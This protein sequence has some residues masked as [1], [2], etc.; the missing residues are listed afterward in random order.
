[1]AFVASP[2][3]D[4]VE[5]LLT[6]L[7]SGVARE[8]NTFSL[9][10]EYYFENSP[11]NPESVRVA[12]IRGK[13]IYHFVEGQDFIADSEKITWK[14]KDGNLPDIGSKFYINYYRADTEPVLSDRNAGSVT[15]TFAEAFGRELAVLYQQ[16]LL[17][18]ESGFVNTAKGDSLD[19]V[20][21]ILGE[22][23]SRKSGDYATGEVLFYR[24]SPATADIFIN[25]GLQVATDTE[26]LKIYETTQE[27]TL[28]KG[29][30][31]VLVPVRAAKKGQEGI[32]EA[33]TI[34]IMVQPVL[35][36]DG[37]INPNS[38]S[39]T[40]VEEKDDE[41]RERAK[42]ALEAAGKTT[43]NALK[44]ALL[45][46]PELWGKDIKVEEDFSQGN[47]LVRVY[48]DTEGTEDVV[49]KIDQKIFETK[50]SGIRVVHNLSSEE[51]KLKIDL[52]KIPLSLKVT[53]SLAD[54]SISS[55][56]KEILKEQ[57]SFVIKSYFEK[58]KIGESAL[59]NKLIAIVLGIEGV[60]NV[61]VDIE[62]G[63]KAGSNE[64]MVLEKLR[65]TIAD[66]PVF[67]D[68]RIQAV[69]TDKKL[70]S[71][72]VEKSIKD[73]ANSFMESTGNKIL[74][75]AFME[76][77]KGNGYNIGSLAFDTESSETGLIKR[78]IMQGEEKINENEVFVLRNI[79]IKVS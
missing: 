44:Y 27:K 52:K 28:R 34:K 21:A 56:K 45:S 3:L 70:D 10:T 20:V 8:E 22:N 62:D 51:G 37:I 67:V 46:I 76:A 40:G 59:K 49:E 73:R 7:T 19:Q 58:L 63:E 15:R 13:A 30:M 39:P 54:P 60:K 11:V 64:K 78:A 16:L 14:K 5:D 24:N 23:Y 48:V 33:G 36:I 65:I 4:I 47:G 61:Q 72:S 69:I 75:S 38:I 55:G 77:L 50:A 53:A 66:S 79:D 32:T 68:L 18:Y 17:I 41:L 26:E 31:S 9:D 12:G 6:A 25:D 71:S 29:Q 43:A 42:H 74:V 57:L 35:G 1:M 2:Y